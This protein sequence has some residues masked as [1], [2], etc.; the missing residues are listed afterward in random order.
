VGFI[1]FPVVASDRRERGN[2]ESSFCWI[3]LAALA[4][5]QRVVAMLLAMT[6]T[7]RIHGKRY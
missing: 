3:A 2:P 4:L 5:A 7:P 6:R 1:A